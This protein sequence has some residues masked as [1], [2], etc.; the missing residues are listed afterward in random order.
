MPNK[1][2]ILLGLEGVGKTKLLYKLHLGENINTVPTGGF[3]VETV[4]FNHIKFTI[5]DLGGRD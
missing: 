3:N 2:L 5:W 4:E 1:R